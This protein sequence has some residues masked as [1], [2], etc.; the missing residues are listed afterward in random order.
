LV[1]ATL[2][3]HIIGSLMYLMNIRLYICFDV[4]TLT[5]YLVEARCFDLVAPNHVMRFLKGTLDYGLF[6]IGDHDF[7]MCVY[8]N[9]DW[10]GSVSDRKSTS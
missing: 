8:T 2:Y 1:D 5:Q 4:N 10:A 7:R 6:Y 3:K 9:S